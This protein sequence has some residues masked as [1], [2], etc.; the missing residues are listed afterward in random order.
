M[1]TQKTEHK[2]NT[3]NKQRLNT[4]NTNE[5]ERARLPERYTYGVNLNTWL[6][7]IYTPLYQPEL[8]ESERLAVVGGSERMNAAER[9]S[10]QVEFQRVVASE[11]MNTERLKRGMG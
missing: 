7:L 11:R 10:E 3:E 1:A 9:S 4:S 2:R 6:N 5:Y 8:M